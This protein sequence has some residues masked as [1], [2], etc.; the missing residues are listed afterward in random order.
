MNVLLSIKPMYANAILDG[1][2]KYEFRKSIFRDKN[3]KK[4]YIYSSSPVKKIVGVFIV[5]GIIEDHPKR[6]W[7]KCWRNSGI[8]EDDFIAYFSG[9]EK[10]YAIMIENPEPLDK[11]ID[12]R[13][14]Y[15]DFVPPQSFY[16]F[17]MPVMEGIENER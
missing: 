14:I 15:R 7:E 5:G 4:V 11:P 9:R 1:E 10:G 12:P 2:K 3:V 8:A 16:Y 17:D 6:I 13:S